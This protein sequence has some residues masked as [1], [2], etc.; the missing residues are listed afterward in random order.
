MAG[1]LSALRLVRE[2]GLDY[3]ERTVSLAQRTIRADREDGD[4]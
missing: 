1:Q 4:A 2:R 3:A